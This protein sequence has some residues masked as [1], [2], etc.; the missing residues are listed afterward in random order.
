MTTLYL[1]TREGGEV[2]LLSSGDAI[3]CKKLCRNYGLTLLKAEQAELKRLVE[4]GA[5][6]Q[7]E[8]TLNVEDDDD[9]DEMWEQFG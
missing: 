3:S 7:T 5:R 4:L 8:D 1:A 6:P 9:L 2:I